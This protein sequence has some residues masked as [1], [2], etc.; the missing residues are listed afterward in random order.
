MAFVEDRWYRAVAGP[1]GKRRRV[2]REDRS[3]KG[4]RYRVRYTDP[5]GKERSRSFAR[6]EDADRFRHTVSADI[7]RGTYL[8]PAAGRITLRAY[9][10]GWLASRSWDA[11]TR[12]VVE[13]RV[14]G[15]I[16]PGLG[17]HR[18]EHVAR[19]PSLVSGWLAG[20]A[21][22]PLHK[23]HVLGT[24]SSVLGA[25]VDDG[26]IARNPCRARS[27]Q[28]PGLPKRRLVPW[29]TATVATVRAELPGRYRAMADTGA[30]AGLRQGEI[31]GL[32]L[33]AV[34]FLRHNIRVRVQVRLIKG[35]L[36]FALPK[37]IRERDVPLPAGLGL[38]LA[39]HIAAF[40][41]V[42]VTLPWKEPGG[43]PHTETLIFTSSR[44]AI[45]RN[46]FNADVWG[47]ARQRAGLPGNREN[48]MHALRHHFA[49]IMLAGGV[50]VG[51]LAEYLG[52]HDPGFT[53]RFYR[54]L[55]PSDA[56]RA[57][58]AVEAAIRAADGP[59]TASGTAGTR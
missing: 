13:A 55:M 52:H 30:H 41:P 54:H 15:H 43:R 12:Q 2:R 48:G 22:S 10:E 20:L 50:D 58:K 45:H 34:N 49:S 5:D 6:K 1:D 18:L 31:I 36:V 46:G 32:P 23:R 16:L 14:N 8:D 59:E 53:L 57:R 44:G 28:P 26:V 11:G 3:D 25:A 27:V 35:T 9:T 42:E 19:R 38:A 21:L 4:K 39:A 47:P 7:I 56:E 51:A 40:P 17:S 24:L 37:G 33:N 29:D